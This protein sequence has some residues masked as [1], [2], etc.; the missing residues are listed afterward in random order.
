MII[1][2]AGLSMAEPSSLPSAAS[3][4]EMCHSKYCESVD[5]DFDPSIK[6]DLEA[7]AEHFAAEGSLVPYFIR[8]LVPWGSFLPP[9]NLGHLALG[10]FLMCKA[11]VAVLSSNY[12]ELIERSAKESGADLQVSLTGDQADIRRPFHSPLLK[13]HGCSTDRDRTIWAKSQLVGDNVIS[14]RMQNIKNW[15]Q[16][17]LR[18]K[19]LLVVGF[20]S[21]WSYLNEIIDSAF[22]Q[23]NPH[24]IT[25]IDLSDINSLEVKAPNLWAAA[26]AHGVS[27]THIQESGASVLDEIRRE[28][29]KGYIRKLLSSG[30][31]AIAHEFGIECD[32]DWFEQPELSSEE[33]HQWRR[34][35]EGL[36]FK[37]FP[38]R[39]EPVEGEV[40]GF[41]HLLLRKNGAV[42]S[43]TQYL[44][45]GRVVR[46]V[47][48]S[49]NKLATI[50]REFLEP[51]AA[52]V[53]EIIVCVGSYD[54]G[55]PDHL[56]RSGVPGSFVR[57]APM[58]NFVTEDEARKVL[59]I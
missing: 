31:P 42:I 50:R 59:G 49:L 33:Y 45:A 57:P 54:D 20:W 5:P 15:M 18:E 8:N 29:S 39:K 41:V 44:I 2:G 46:V 24:S 14:D 38:R 22:S 40:L 26:H 51:A 30:R 56:I 13:F 6:Y 52:N 16:V 32:N 23:V 11:V 55:L 35:A 25:L 10:D 7:I 17:N 43:G 28:F 12:D 58:P 21:D 48:G 4:A 9:S 19:D 1:C 34:D 37:K 53:D 27:F 36:G 47:N 3:L